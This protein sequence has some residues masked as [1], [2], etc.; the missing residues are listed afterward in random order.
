MP[1]PP[2]NVTLTATDEAT[3]KAIMALAHWCELHAQ[4]LIGGARH[5]F[6]IA[7]SPLAKNAIIRALPPDLSKVLPRYLL[8][9]PRFKRRSKVSRLKR[10][11]LLKLIKV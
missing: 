5:G 9:V 11:C 3:E 8:D 6:Q 4:A 2:E 7:M 1:T 10:W